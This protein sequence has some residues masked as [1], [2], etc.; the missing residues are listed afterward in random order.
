MKSLLTLQAWVADSSGAAGR[1]RPSSVRRMLNCVGQRSTG[2][3][4]DDD[5]DIGI[6]ATI[7]H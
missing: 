5:I 6:G 7:A 1:K 2:P 4:S 3:S